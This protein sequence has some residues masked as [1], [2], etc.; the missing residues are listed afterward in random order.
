M[1]RGMGQQIAA[2]GS[3]MH[4]KAKAVDVGGPDD[5]KQVEVIKLV[6][7]AHSDLFTGKVLKE[8]NGCVHFEVR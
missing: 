8:R 2:P 7:A 5:A 3:S 1:V 6:A 4:Q